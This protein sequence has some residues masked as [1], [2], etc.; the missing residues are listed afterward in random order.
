MATSPKRDRRFGLE[1]V[2]VTALVIACVAS[3]TYLRSYPGHR[4][5]ADPASA[6]RLVP[7][8]PEQAT[9]QAPEERTEAVVFEAS[10]PR[11]SGRWLGRLDLDSRSSYLLVVELGPGDRLTLVVEGRQPDERRVRYRC[12]ARV[13]ASTCLSVLDAGELP[14]RVEL[15][16]WYRGRV[17]RELLGLS[18]VRLSPTYSWLR[19][20]LRACIWLAPI[21]F[22]FRYRR[23]LAAQLTSLEA[24]DDVV[25]ALTVFGLCFLLFH[26][27]PVQQVLDSRYLTAVSHSVL[28]GR[29]V[30]LAEGFGPGQRDPLPYQLDRI[31]GRLLHHYSPIPALLDAPVVAAYEWFGVTPM[32]PNG[33]RWDFGTEKR[34]MRFSAA[35]VASM[36]CVV[37]YLTAR[38]LLPPLHS[39]GL[40]FAF[41]FGTQ[42]FRTLSRPYWSHTCGAL[43]AAL[44]IYFVVFPSRRRT[45]LSMVLGATCV[46]WSVF[47]RPQNFWTVIGLVVFLLLGR[48]W[49][50]V[51]VFLGVGLGWAVA[52]ALFS[53]SIYGSVLPD[54]F[55][56]AQV[57][58]ERFGV[59]RLSRNRYPRFF[60]GSLFSPSRG[61][62]VFVPLLG[63]VLVVVGL[64]WKRL[65]LRT[66]ASIALAVIAG[67]L[68]LLIH[69]G[70]WSGAQSFG[71]RQLSD[72]LVWF[73]L[74]AVLAVQ[75]LREAWPRTGR[76]ER[77]LLLA[78]LALC[79]A[80]SVFVNARG[81]FSR[82]TWTWEV[83][84]YRNV[85]R[86][87][88]DPM[89]LS[90]WWNWRR[91][92][93]MAGLSPDGD[94]AQS[95]QS[96]S[97][98]E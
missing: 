17:S 74:L 59:D 35:L 91:P 96:E 88:G 70:T 23:R 7:Q 61:L 43:L 42:I 69:T 4:L 76:V 77:R 16:A 6:Q 26:S 33:G 92:Q 39:L 82:A 46:S 94:K 63:W 8:A 29:G 28:H 90:D 19:L 53:L 20:L 85:D 72:V 55:L 10:H 9:E 40:T 54:Y 79:V 65:A 57:E 95:A 22:L 45:S 71:P 75:A 38:K 89:W 13:T 36:L 25:F 11:T 14:T 58:L 56:R 66:V 97:P 81:A 49:R 32:S 30:E 24:R 34:I 84:R 68:W 5:F 64:L 15:R 47:V 86:E 48:R 3:L 62:F 52:G 78:T 18:A 60:L 87:E 50:R 1:L 31:E 44:A 21:G 27:A 73:F 93:F 98:R 41:A 2:L 51:G 37:L 83:D 67:H 12:A 80:F